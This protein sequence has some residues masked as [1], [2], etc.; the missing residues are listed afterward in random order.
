MRDLSAARFVAPRSRYAI[1]RTR[2]INRPMTFRTRPRNSRVHRAL[3]SLRLMHDIRSSTR[4]MLVARFALA[5]ESSEWQFHRGG[6]IVNV[7]MGFLVSKPV[8]ATWIG[9]IVI[10]GAAAYGIAAQT[11][12][13]LGATFERRILAAALPE[14]AFDLRFFSTAVKT[15][16]S[17]Q[18]IT[19]VNAAGPRRLVGAEAAG[20][21]AGLPR[22]TKILFAN[23]YNTGK[24]SAGDRID[25]N[26][27][28]VKS[29]DQH[30]PFVKQPFRSW[31]NALA[32]TADG[33]KLYVTLPGREG[34]P[35]WRVAVVDARVRRVL[36][37][38]DLRP[39]GQT[40]G[41]RPTGI[42]IS[43]LNTAVYPRQYVVVANEYANFASVL[44]TSTDA[45]IGEFQTD[46]YGEDLIFNPACTRLYLTDRFKDQVRAF[47]IAAGPSF[48][49]IAQIPTGATDLDRANPRDLALSADA[50]T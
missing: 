30:W 49:E 44:D 18:I 40:R 13:T 39:A 29:G 27:P 19:D 12:A 6:E 3:A 28:L 14:A 20:E 24:P 47:A 5:L 8:W 15:D 2:V 35:D 26:N 1:E 38:V 50:N 34:D 42:A 22:F 10:A 33:A 36:R 17:G 7:R 43:P 48:T 11:A 21:R 9:S 46:F 45:V 32:V 41:T 16:T 25:P 37:W 23:Q 31:P 4:G